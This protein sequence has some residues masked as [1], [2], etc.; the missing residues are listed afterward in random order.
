MGDAF[1]LRILPPI[2]AHQICL[3]ARYRSDLSLKRYY[4]TMALDTCNHINHERRGV[5]RR[6]YFE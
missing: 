2:R 3:Y 4:R 1:W 6:R 5:M